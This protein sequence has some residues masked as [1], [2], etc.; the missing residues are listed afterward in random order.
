MCRNIIIISLYT[1][2]IFFLNSCKSGSSDVMI[3][4]GIPT[5]EYYRVVLLIID[6]RFGCTG[7][8]I[9]HNT[10]L[11]AAHCLAKV[12]KENPEVVLNFERSSSVIALSTDKYMANVDSS[13][14]L[15]AT[16]HDD[17]YVRDIGV[18]VFPDNTFVG[19]PTLKIKD[20]NV[21]PQDRVLMVGYGTY[22]TTTTN[23]DGRKVVVIDTSRPFVKRYGRN[24][25]YDSNR[26]KSVA[27][28]ASGMIQVNQ[29]LAFSDSDSTTP[30][31]ED[32]IMWLID[33]GGPLFLDSYDTVDKIIGVASYASEDY[34]DG[35]YGC[36]VSVSHPDNIKFLKEAV[37]KLHAHIEF[38]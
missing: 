1:M 21:S 15:N 4:N 8:I 11:T 20:Y 7:T 26:D 5:S 34:V 24:H 10:V 14:F 35:R 36:Y 2:V 33:S 38:E 31:G 30:T 25:I 19:V 13:S 37:K 18:V 17:I 12:S 9:S 6:N 16:D 28:C 22:T 23:E 27:S 3:T 29:Q 32:T